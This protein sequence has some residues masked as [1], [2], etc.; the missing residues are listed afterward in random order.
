MSGIVYLGQ[1]KWVYENLEKNYRHATIEPLVKS[2]EDKKHWI[3]SIENPVEE[4]PGRGLV[5][6]HDA[7]KGLEVGEVW[8]FRVDPHPHYRGESDKEAFQ[9]RNP[10]YP[11]EIID[12]FDTGS[13]RDIRILLTTKGIFLKN[14]PLSKRCVLRVQEKKWIGPVNLTQRA[15]TNSWIFESQQDLGLIRCWDI[16]LDAIQR[17]ELDGTRWLLAPNQDKLGQHIGFVNWEAD[18]VLAQRVLKHLSKQFPETA[19]A[20]NVSKKVFKAYVDKIEKAGLVGSQLNQELAFHERI[21]ELLDVISRNEEL[22][23]E[24]ANVC[25]AIGPI[26]EKIGRKAEE[27]YY[28]MEAENKERLRNELASIETELKTTERKKA[29]LEKQTLKLEE[30]LEKSISGFDSKLEERLREL[31]EKP[32]RFFADMAIAK[33]LGSRSGINREKPNAQVQLRKGDLDPEIPLVEEQ[34]TLIGTISNRLLGSGISPIV[35]QA[36]HSSLL[37]GLV[38]VLTGPEAYEVVSAY[39]DCISGGMLHWIPLGGSIFEP[40]DLLARFDPT[41]RC[42]VPHPGGLLDLLL[43]ESDTIHVVVLEG[44]NRAAVDG[45]LIPLLQSAQDLAHGRKPRQIPLAPP[46]FASKDDLYS[47]V[48]RIAWNSDVLLVLCP[49]A[50]ASTLPIPV[51]FWTHCTFLDAGDPAPV[52]TVPEPGSTPQMTRVSGTIWNAWSE[53][54]KEKIEPL[55]VLRKQPKETSK[56]PSVVLD[57][58]ESIY[59]TVVALGFTQERALEQAAKISLL[60]YLSAREDDVDTWFKHLGISLSEKDQEISV[61]VKRMGE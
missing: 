53:E 55:E 17:V 35:G 38:P 50:G 48:S 21:K 39:A 60:P 42:L 61:A 20:L 11:M 26:K 16:P 27:E 3:G 15:G 6:W 52:R 14:P 37:A 54:A 12:L 36:L 10:K 9:V 47:G 32:E 31:A 23:D 59:G 46:G 28:R 29:S 1:V 2:S 44:F 5:Y 51:E 4:L 41:S 30:E 22:L 8:Q 56:L 45:Y 19:N 49:T 58:V 13:E 34:K 24:A 25:F 7:P 18:E 57:N 40:S 33:A 43:D